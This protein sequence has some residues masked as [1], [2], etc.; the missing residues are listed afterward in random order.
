MKNQIKN[1]LIQLAI[2]G[3][4]PEDMT[5]LDMSIFNIPDFNIMDG[6]LVDEYDGGSTITCFD[7]IAV[8][9]NGKEKFRMVYPFVSELTKDMIIEIMGYRYANNWPYDTPQFEDVM[10]RYGQV[11][12]PIL[13]KNI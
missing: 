3:E 9:S 7:G 5:T 13:N 11:V 10:M 6:A 2:S 8:G 12:K 4:L 1:K